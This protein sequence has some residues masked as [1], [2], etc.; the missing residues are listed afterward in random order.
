MIRKAHTTQWTVKIAVYISVCRLVYMKPKSSSEANSARRLPYYRQ[1]KTTVRFA[2][3]FP[4]GRFNGF[5]VA[6]AD[7]SER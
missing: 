2:F 6:I 3:G 1:S 5:S 7:H 4:H